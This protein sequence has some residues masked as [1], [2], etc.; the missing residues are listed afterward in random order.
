M[1]T[2]PQDP[3]ADTP[4]VETAPRRGGRVWLAGA[5]VFVGG[6]LVL[7]SLSSQLVT[8]LAGFGSG[9][10]AHTLFLLAQL[11]FA[12]VVVVVGLLGAPG[13]LAGKLL[14]AAIVVVG[15]PIVVLFL[16]VRISGLLRV[17]PESNFTIGNPWLMTVLLVGAAWLLARGA[18]LGWLSLLGVVIL[19]PIPYWLYAANLDA[20]FVPLVMFALTGL[21][22]A[23]ILLAGRPWRD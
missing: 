4:A 12:V 8:Q 5:L 9:S 23:G 16:T 18:R 15:V 11:A 13:H 14:G 20:G 1:T 22:G 19:S 21:V 2:I 6:Y 10:P 17:G 7:L 3:Y